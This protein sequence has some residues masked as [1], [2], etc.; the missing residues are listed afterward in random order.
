MIYITSFEKELQ[1]EKWNLKQHQIEHIAGRELLAY[2]LQQE[3]QISK[4]M[5][6]LEKGNYGK[7]YLKEYPELFFNITHCKEMAACGITTKNIG[8]DIEGIRKF[9]SEILKKVLTEKEKKQLEDSEQKEEMFFRF[10]TL[11]ESFIKAIGKGLSFPL[12]DIS[13]QL[14]KTYE[15]DIESNQKGYSFY[16][17]RI[18]ARFILSI[19]LKSEKIPDNLKHFKEVPVSMFFNSFITN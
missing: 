17:R 19:C 10:W 11:K 4:E 12:Q 15:G 16:Q 3:Y 7:P 1:R 2:G 5:I 14:P 18:D 13:F 6:L 8:I 9:S